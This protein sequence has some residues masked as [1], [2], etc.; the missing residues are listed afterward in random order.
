MNTHGIPPE[1]KQQPKIIL[2]TQKAQNICVRNK[3]AM[4]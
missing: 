1:R 2:K 4:G 3:E